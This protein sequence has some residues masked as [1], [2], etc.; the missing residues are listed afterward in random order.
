MKK[1]KKPKKR[2]NNKSKIK[3]SKSKKLREKKSKNK[4]NSAWNNMSRNKK[5]WDGWRKKTT[6]KKPIIKK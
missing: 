1:I 2:I 5:M 3:K 4:K 6:K